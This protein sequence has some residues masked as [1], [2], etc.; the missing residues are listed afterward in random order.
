MSVSRSRRLTGTSSLFLLAI[1]AGCS[2]SGQT[3][4][5]PSDKPQLD[6]Q[7]L[8]VTTTGWD[9]TALI[10]TAAG[11]QGWGL[12]K[13]VSQGA[14]GSIN[15]TT[16]NATTLLTSKGLE[17]AVGATE[18]GL[19]LALTNPCNGDEVG[20]GGQG[21]LFMNF[22]GVLAAGSTLTQ[23][24]LGSV[25]GS[26]TVSTQEGWEI[27][28][29]T[30]GLGDG[31]TGYALLSSGFGNG[32]NNAG[33][34]ITL[35]GAPLPLATANLVLRFQKYLAAPGNATTD[36]DYVVKSVTTAF[37]E[38]EGCTFTWGYWKTHAGTKRQADAWPAGA[39]ATGLTLGT[40]VYTK[41]QLLSIMNT[42]PAGN[43]L[44]S[45][46]HQLIAAKLNV[47]PGT[48]ADITAADL[49]IGA[50]IVPPVGSGFLDPSVTSTLNDALTAFNEGRTGPGHCDDVEVL[51]L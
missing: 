29:S 35:T 6:I 39:T 40:V 11:C 41:A 27:W 48:T 33:D 9:F 22:N 10:G 4:L 23:V 26:A 47:Y 20:D 19:G 1:V 49:L 28:Y 17:L 38:A 12:S 24:D 25:Q 37:E 32:V 36:N 45:L 7:A 50:L 46:A 51:R 34:N 16:G 3:P 2:E 21:S 14:F 5:A 8:V 42:P 30:T 15:L 43:G 31:T 13:L 44:I 18:R